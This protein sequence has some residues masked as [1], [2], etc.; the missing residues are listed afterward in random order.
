MTQLTSVELGDNDVPP[1][2]LSEILNSV[3][4]HRQAAGPKKH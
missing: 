4:L 2:A 3:R 1:E